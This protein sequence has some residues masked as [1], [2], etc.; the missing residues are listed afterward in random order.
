MRFVVNYSR[1]QIMYLNVIF[2]QLDGFKINIDLK[3]LGV[4][5]FSMNK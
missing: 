2:I 3:Q 1:E 5:V 4:Y